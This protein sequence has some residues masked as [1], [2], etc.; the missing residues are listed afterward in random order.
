MAL[1]SAF[2]QPGIRPPNSA[3]FIVAKWINSK[4]AS[5]CLEFFAMVRKLPPILVRP[6]A[7]SLEERG[8]GAKVILKSRG[9]VFLL[10]KASSSA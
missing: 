8:S 2:F 1:P 6:G 5:L 7:V 10:V 3:P 4:A 9:Y